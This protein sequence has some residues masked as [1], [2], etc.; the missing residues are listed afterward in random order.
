M[1]AVDD[2]VLATG[3]TYRESELVT[4]RVRRRGRRIDVD[5]DG[6]AVHLAG[7]PD[8]WLQVAREVV[9]SYDLN[10]NR[11]GVVFVP[12]VEGRDVERIGARL[13]DCS[14]SVYAA[15]LELED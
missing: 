12:L 1:A 14:V 6:G 4:V 15:L 5:D 10:V 8:G 13:A 2:E 11:A 9:E 7:R 3:R